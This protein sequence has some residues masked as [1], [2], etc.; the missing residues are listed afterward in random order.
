MTKTQQST[1]TAAGIRTTPPHASKKIRTNADG[2]PETPKTRDKRKQKTKRAKANVA[3]KRAKPFAAVLNTEP[4]ENVAKA[5]LN[6]EPV[7]KVAKAAPKEVVAAG[8]RNKRKQTT[9]VRFRSLTPED[10]LGSGKHNS[11]DSSFVPLEDDDRDEESEDDDGDEESKRHEEEAVHDDS[12][13]DDNSNDS[14]ASYRREAA[15]RRAEA[16]AELKILEDEM[17]A[18]VRHTDLNCRALLRDA[19]DPP[20]DATPTATSHARLNARIA[21]PR[22]LTNEES[23]VPR[24]ETHVKRRNV[25]FVKTDLFRKIKFVNSAS[26]FQRAF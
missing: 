20:N 21:I 2:K 25:L 19:E 13:D 4:V 3:A 26:M 16:A 12:S 15:E 23:N 10:V 7:E 5:V 24:E 1:S 11:D 9:P 8:R 6:T 22:G 17:E 18:E 14:L